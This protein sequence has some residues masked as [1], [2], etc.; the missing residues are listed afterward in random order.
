M[1]DAFARLLTSLIEDG[2]APRSRFS[3]RSLVALGSLFDA[4]V[5]RQ[6]RRGG[7]L[8]I[9]VLDPAT[10]ARF[11]RQ[12]YPSQGVEIEGPPR[13]VAAAVLRSAKRVGRTDCE[14]VLLRAL[15]P[16]DGQRDGAACD[17]RAVTDQTG[18]ACLILEQGRFW[19]LKEATIAVVENLE[20]FLHFERLGPPADVALYACG[21]LSDLALHWLA[22][23][24]LSTCRLLHCGDYDPV[25]L[26]EYLRLKARVGDRVRLHVPE[27]L[28]DLVATYGRPELLRDSAGVLQ[29]LR[30]SGD[31]AVRQVVR[32][33]DET[34]CGLEQEVLLIR[35][36][37]W[38]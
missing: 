32:L 33:L 30:A 17:L 10:L 29:R 24:E 9:E 3:P 22:S 14:P 8:I 35:T 36:P 38:G 11:Y 13:A 34:G 4:G 16:V 25:G 27:N 28:G 5:L 37:G 31:P 23:P 26:D 15:R 1:P 6:A 18:A 21:R 20:C 19:T 12:R 2:S 7:G